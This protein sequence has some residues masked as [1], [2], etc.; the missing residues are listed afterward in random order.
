MMVMNTVWHAIQ[1]EGV[2]LIGEATLILLSLYYI[3][4]KTSVRTARL[5]LFMLCSC[6]WQ[7]ITA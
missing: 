6:A 3:H 1:D 4:Y 5:S 7:S 2:V